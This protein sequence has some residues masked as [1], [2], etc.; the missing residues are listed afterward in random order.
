MIEHLNPAIARIRTP[1]HGVMDA[2][3][4]VSA[5][6]VLTCAH[7]VRRAQDMSEVSVESLPLDFAPI[8]LQYLAHL[9]SDQRRG[10]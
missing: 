1:D 2:G 10:G 6:Q 7:V 9:W 5:R 4:L 3:F 8:K